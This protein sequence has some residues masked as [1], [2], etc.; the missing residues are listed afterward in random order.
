MRTHIKRYTIC[1]GFLI[2]YLGISTVTFAQEDPALA[3][4]NARS[5]DLV[6]MLIAAFLV[7]FMQPGFAMVEAGFTRA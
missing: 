3:E 4:A 7:F 2:L 1:L 6:W 5:I